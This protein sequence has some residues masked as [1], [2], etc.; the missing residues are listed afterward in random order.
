MLPSL[1]LTDKNLLLLFGRFI[2]K[3]VRKQ[4]NPV[5]ARQGNVTAGVIFRNLGIR[6]MVGHKG[7]NCFN[8]LPRGTKQ[9]IT[10]AAGIAGLPIEKVRSTIAGMITRQLATA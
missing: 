1:N 2:M 9:H 5:F 3:S 7:I 4:G 10:K 8:D 6:A